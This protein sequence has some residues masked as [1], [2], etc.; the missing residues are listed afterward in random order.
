MAESLGWDHQLKPL[1]YRP[2]AEWLAPIL[3]AS[4][5]HLKA[6][7]R[8]QFRGPLPDIVIAAGRR[9]E[10]AARWI[11][12]RSRGRT[13]VIYL[14]QPAWKRGIDLSI[15]PSHD[16]PAASD[17]VMTTLGPPH[18]LTRA[19]ISNA[20]RQ[21]TRQLEDS[22]RPQIAV[23]VGGSSKRAVFD[24]GEAERLVRQVRD[25][26]GRLDAEL[27][28][29]TSRRTGVAQSD[30]LK[31]ALQPRLF[32]GFGSEGPNPYP[33]LLGLA[34]RVVV[35]SDSA[36]MMAE[37]CFAG[38]PVH[39][40]DV[41]GT[42]AKLKT[43]ATGLEDGGWIRPWTDEGASLP[44]PLDVKEDAAQAI[45]RLW[46]NRQTQPNWPHSISRSRTSLD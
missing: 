35:T 19:V 21:V 29:T 20:A 45:R 18:R 15:V 43:L 23:L 9:T 5:L 28:V 10:T 1:H 41:K 24:R 40:F 32:H 8:N 6:S 12:N 3:G 44:P 11:K 2:G 34:S 22:S 4:L 46:T 13:V 39:L 30:Y 14:M 16:Q 37:A 38:V 31:R 7:A 42:P 33:G 26:A 27:L 25:L 36:S 17:G